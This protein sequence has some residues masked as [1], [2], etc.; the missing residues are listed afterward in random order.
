LIVATMAKKPR[1][2]MDE[3]G[4][5]RRRDGVA[6]AP[7][8]E[9]LDSDAKRALADARLRALAFALGS[10]G[11][12]SAPTD[13][14]DDTELLAYLLDTLPEHRRMALEETLR[15]NA[16]A[17]GR[18][19]TLRAALSS[20][21]DKRDRQRADDA[22]RKIRRRTA[23]RVDIRRLGKILQFRDAA[24]PRSSFDLQRLAVAEP[25]VAALADELSRPLAFR[26]MRRPETESMLRN[27]LE[28][29]RRDLDAGMRL[30]NEALSSLQAW[31]NVRRRAESETRGSGAPADRDAENLCERL[32]ELLRELEIVANRIG[33]LTSA[34]GG[35]FPRAQVAAS[36]SL[37]TPSDADLYE[38]LS[39]RRLPT[40]Q[41]SWADAFDLEAGPWAIHLTGNAIPT[42]R[43]VVSLRE[44]QVGMPSDDLFLTLVRP[45]EGFETVN[46]DSSGIG[47]IALPTGD[48]VM[49][50]QADEVW[51]VRLSFR[52]F[53]R[54]AR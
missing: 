27:L 38:G 31:W 37:E 8:D 2:G 43:L 16:R 25:K 47:E 51:E 4:I 34:T 35:M 13:H 46:L 19:M 32:T 28:R 23:G 36:L 7:P 53:S 24:R 29:A 39:E 3:E 14:A 48:S 12:P 5:I 22:A 17:F 54:G 21:T 49:L 30:V 26:E 15:G 10:E 33:D 6:S 50:L 1:S 40:D 18:L 44:D 11:S 20:P 42:P 9:P 45:A 41:E 52:D